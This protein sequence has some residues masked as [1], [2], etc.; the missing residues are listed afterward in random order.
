MILIV[1]FVVAVVL[2]IGLCH[3]LMGIKAWQLALVGFV[4]YLIARQ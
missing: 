2:F 1:P 3:L 4:V